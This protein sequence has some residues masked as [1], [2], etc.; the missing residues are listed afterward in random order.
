MTEVERDKPWLF[1][2]YAGHSTAAASNALYRANLARARPA[3][4]SPSICRPRPAMT[5]TTSWR[6]ARSARSACRSAISATCARS[7][8]TSR[9]TQM[10]TSMTI[11]AT[12]AW[13]LALYIAVAEE[14]G[15]DVAALQGTV[16]NDI[17][18]EYL[19]RGTY[20]FPPEPS[21]RMI[22]DVAAH[23]AEHLPK[24]NPMNVCSYHLQEAGATPEQ[25]LAF[26]LATAIAVLDD[27]RGKV[28]A[29]RVSRRWSGASRFFVN[30]GIR[31][32]TETVQDA[33]LRRS[34][35]R[36][37]PRSLRHH[38]SELPPLPLRRAGQLASG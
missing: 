17:I 20:I 28:A 15:A 23:T 34:L 31:F 4:R 35:G 14:Q 2:T 32:V 22:T 3:S 18:K 6:G 7:S 11:N 25:E 12:A 37:L 27:L 9:S 29:A 36:D 5:A 38:G 19:S 26:A 30:A 16:Q 10:N 21:L 8:R 1:R 33:R 24:W 13:L